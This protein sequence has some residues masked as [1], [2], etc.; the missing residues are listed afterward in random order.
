MEGDMMK[1]GILLFAIVSALLMHV[2][3]VYSAGSEECG[4]HRMS[5]PFTR[6]LVGSLEKSGFEVSVGCPKLYTMQDCIDHTYPSL[7]S[8]FSANPAAPYVMPVMKSWPDEYVDPALANA[9]VKTDPGYSATY[10]LDPREAIVMFGTMPPPGRYMGLQTIELSKHG[11]WRPR[12]YNNWANT[13]G[14]PLPIQYLFQTVPPGDPKS[15]RVVTVSALGDLV[16]NVVMERQSGYPFGK[17][18]Y[19][20]ITP[21]ATTEKAVRRTLQAQGVKDTHIF[22]QQIPREDDYG[23]IGPLGMGENAID[24]L[25]MF[26]YAVPDDQNAAQQ[27]RS[28]LPLTVLRLRAPASLGPVQRYK[29]LTFEQRKGYS[30]ADLADDLKN[31]VDAV[32]DRVTNYTT[33][34]SLDCAQKPPDSS[35]MVEMGRDLGWVGPYCRSIDM[36]CNVDQQESSLYF[37]PLSSLDAGQVLAIVGT[38]ATE[39]GNA[40]YVGLSANDASILGGVANVMDTDVMGPDGPIKGLKGSADRYATSVNNTGKFFV[41]YFTKDCTVL[42]PED[43]ESCSPTNGVDPAIGDPTLRGKFIIV[44]RDYIATRTQRGPDVSKRLTPR[45]LMFTK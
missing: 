11:T 18:R 40:V 27:W 43:R 38:L 24:F 42:P 22:T 31:L 32:C 5:D 33:L 14:V 41:H 44:L 20:I 30:E 3:C 45:V 21:S 17:T 23:P 8:C 16:N 29:S 36:N 26:R 1:T 15:H 6:T 28:D 13:P 7:K 9:F 2:P 4:A 19:F 34:A 25:T 39:T 37:S 10:R 12:D 35:Y